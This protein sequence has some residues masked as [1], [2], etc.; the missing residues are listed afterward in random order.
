MIL[1]QPLTWVSGEDGEQLRS[2]LCRTRTSIQPPVA[3]KDTSAV[4]LAFGGKR[5]AESTNER[6]Q[7]AGVRVTTWKGVSRCQ[8]RPNIHA[9]PEENSPPSARPPHEKRVTVSP[10]CLR[11][12]KLMQPCVYTHR[13]SVTFC[14]GQAASETYQTADDESRLLG[15]VVLAGRY[16]VPL[17]VWRTAAVYERDGDEILPE[18]PGRRVNRQALP[19]RR[20]DFNFAEGT[21]CAV[22]ALLR[23]CGG[24]RVQGATSPRNRH[25]SGRVGDSGPG[26][27]RPCSGT[28]ACTRRSRP[29]C[30]NT[31]LS[32]CRCP[33]CIRD[34]SG[35][36]RCFVTRL[37]AIDGGS[38][39][40]SCTACTCRGRLAGHSCRFTGFSP[41]G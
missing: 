11:P 31:C 35:R 14:L 19:V 30:R 38:R 17:L 15:V 8:V 3:R 39:Y 7:L 27:G 40:G 32:N 25:R 5:K 4:V 29:C 10:A 37:V 36:S 2:Q 28:G 6:H 9:V 21:G 23:L 20:P 12:S 22:V 24:S 18:V 13:I 33:F 26:L 41:L 34:R 16:D 1:R